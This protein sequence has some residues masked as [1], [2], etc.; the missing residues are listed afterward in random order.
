MGTLNQDTHN[1]N[2][3]LGDYDRS[4]LIFLIILAFLEIVFKDKLEWLISLMSV[5]AQR[6]IDD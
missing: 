3:I 4:Q 2:F 1:R 6:I 5:E